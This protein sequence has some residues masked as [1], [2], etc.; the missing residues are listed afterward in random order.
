MSLLSLRAG[1]QTD[2]S[3]HTTVE[4][5]FEELAA[6]RL[7]RAS[8]RAAKGFRWFGKSLCFRSPKLAGWARAEALSVANVQPLSMESVEAMPKY[9]VVRCFGPLASYDKVVFADVTR[10]GTTTTVV[11]VVSCKN[12]SKPLLSRVLD[13]EPFTKFVDFAAVLHHVEQPAN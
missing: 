1:R 10:A 6:G 4:K 11:A 3:A 5:F 12:P 2:G 7:D 8:R 13:P 9:A